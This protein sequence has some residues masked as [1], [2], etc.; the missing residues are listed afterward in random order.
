MIDTTKK[1]DKMRRDGNAVLADVSRLY[2]EKLHLD[3]KLKVTGV[4]PKYLKVY[5][6]GKKVTVSNDNVTF[7]E[8]KIEWNGLFEWLYKHI[9]GNDVEH[10]SLHELKDTSSF[11]KYCG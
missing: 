6:N 4:L 7:F 1:L 11:S 2:F 10:W 3:I 8:T 5:D 9:S